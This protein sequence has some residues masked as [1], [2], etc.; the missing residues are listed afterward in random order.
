[1]VLNA[2]S[3]PGSTAIMG[4]GQQHK[5]SAT[6]FYDQGERD[7][8]ETAA[9]TATEPI[10]LNTNPTPA[11][12]QQLKSA[13]IKVD[14]EFAA[15]F[16][17][18]HF[19]DWRFPPPDTVSSPTII[20]KIA[21]EC[22]APVLPVM[23]GSIL[24]N[25]S[26]SIG[27]LS[28]SEYERGVERMTYGTYLNRMTH[29]TYHSEGRPTLDD[30]MTGI[31][32]ESAPRMVSKGGITF[33]SSD[34]HW[35]TQK[36][37]RS[38]DSCSTTETHG[39]PFRFSFDNENVGTDRLSRSK[40][41]QAAST[42]IDCPWPSRSNSPHISFEDWNLF[43]GP[44]GTR[45]SPTVVEQ[46]I[47]DSMS[48]R[49]REQFYERMEPRVTMIAKQPVTGMRGRDVISSQ[50]GG[51]DPKNTIPVSAINPSCPLVDLSH[52]RPTLGLQQ[53][54][55]EGILS[56]IEKAENLLN[57]PGAKL[58][59]A[60]SDQRDKVHGDNCFDQMAAETKR[61]KM[62]IDEQAKR[63]QGMMETSQKSY[64]KRRIA[65]ALERKVTAELT[66]AVLSSV[67]PNT[68]FTLPSGES[69]TVEET[70]RKLRSQAFSSPGSA[71]ASEDTKLEDEDGW[72]SVAIEMGEHESD[73]VKVK[74]PESI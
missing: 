18:G 66:V 31:G 56:K 36:S 53:Q 42:G 32:A 73:W 69:T 44:R 30:Y 41:T 46:E 50:S 15:Y 59:N 8:I 4:G 47:I 43:N 54:R 33:P 13:P 19:L 51:S 26:S 17:P 5:P 16:R 14:K 3:M 7:L 34:R 11:S 39:S 9:A 62:G 70:L 37:S 10:D 28:R 12:K 38:S 71:Q 61:L 65:R 29:G 27:D 23:D 35:Q 21:T 20:G 60:A 63:V 2:T 48:P 45:C 6:Q 24:A 22:K 64:T 55:F 58:T 57:A 68:L 74:S 49:S 40:T 1:M 72:E 25:S 52:N 67:D